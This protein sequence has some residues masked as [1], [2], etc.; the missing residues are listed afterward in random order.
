MN[1]HTFKSAPEEGIGYPVGMKMPEDMRI[2]KLCTS[3][4]NENMEN[5]AIEGI[6]LLCMGSSG[7]IIAALFASDCKFDCRIVHIKKDGEYSHNSYPHLAPS[8]VNIIIDDFTA[9]GTTIK[10]I[11][12]NLEK[13]TN[14]YGLIMAGSLHK[15]VIK[16]T[17]P[18]H[19]V[20]CNYID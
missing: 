13:K 8:Y 9:T 5:D 19:I 4:F 17:K 7:A 6:N 15:H 3:V 10:N 20:V 12:K 1:I 14:I 2:I 18:S 11:I 16:K